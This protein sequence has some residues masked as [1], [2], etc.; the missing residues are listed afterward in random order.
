MELDWVPLA[1]ELVCEVTYDQLDD[2][3]FRDPARFRCWR[4]DREPESC[5]LEQLDRRAVP[6][7]AILR[8]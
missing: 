1:P 6:A 3:R 4:P 8:A 2:H 7:E 5:A